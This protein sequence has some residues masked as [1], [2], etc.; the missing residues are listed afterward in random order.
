MIIILIIIIILLMAY[1][2]SMKKELKKIADFIDK[3]KGQYINISI[4]SNDKD[5]E[6][7]VNK[8]N[9]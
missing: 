2:V 1:I 6:A 9:Y 5:I 7:L 8:I 3:S 4:S